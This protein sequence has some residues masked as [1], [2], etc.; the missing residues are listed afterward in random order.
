LGLPAATVIV[1]LVVAG[2]FLG[3]LFAL[4]CGENVEPGTVRGDACDDVGGLWSFTW[5]LAVL[6]P[7]ALF[8][9]S[10]LIP[11]LRKHPISVAAVIGLL[12]AAFWTAL[13]L[14]VS[15]NLGS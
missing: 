3:Q 1:A 11:Q 4:G 7:A 2:H 13:L 9:L 8:A 14:A 15:G 6:W 12:M 10:Q 5:W